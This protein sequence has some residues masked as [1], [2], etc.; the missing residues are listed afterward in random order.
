MVAAVTLHNYIRREAHT[1]W[2]FEKY[3]YDD[4]IVIDSDDEDE[5]DDTFVGFMLSHLTTKMDS[6]WDS[7]VNLM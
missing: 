7:L 6:F 2:L 1:A 3:G 4:I 5:E